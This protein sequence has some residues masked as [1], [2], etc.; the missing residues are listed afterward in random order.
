MDLLLLALLVALAVWSGR[1]VLTSF[2]TSRARRRRAAFPGFSPDNPIALTSA[3]VLDDAK[4]SL[5]CECGGEVKD[6]GETSRMGLRVARGRCVECDRD[7]D[8]YFTVP[9]LLH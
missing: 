5:R 3:R 9:Q 7:I 1:K 8:L 2:Q 4:A 6:L